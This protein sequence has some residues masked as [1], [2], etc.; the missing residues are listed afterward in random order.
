MYVDILSG[1]ELLP[2]SNQ[3]AKSDWLRST[4][5]HLLVPIRIYW[6]PSLEDLDPNS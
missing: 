4:D 6:N 1:V 2:G 5:K 3:K